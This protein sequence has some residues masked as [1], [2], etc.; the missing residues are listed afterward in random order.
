MNMLSKRFEKV[1]IIAEGQEISPDEFDLIAR[2]AIQPFTHECPEVIFNISFDTLSGQ[3][4]MT[5]KL[6]SKYNEIPFAFKIFLLEIQLSEELN[7]TAN[8]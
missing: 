3:T 2:I 5:R 4:M 6:V 1:E 8:Q 7:K